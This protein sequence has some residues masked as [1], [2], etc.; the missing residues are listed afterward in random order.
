M[1][2]MWLATDVF[3]EAQ[4]AQLTT[5]LQLYDCLSFITS[6]RTLKFLFE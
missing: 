1:F 5:G 3:N 6:L 4:K 2:K